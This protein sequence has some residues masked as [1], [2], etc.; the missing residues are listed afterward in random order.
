M[1]KLLIAAQ[2]IF[3]GIHATHCAD[4]LTTYQQAEDRIRLARAAR[5]TPLHHAARDGH[6]A[7]IGALLSV[8]VDVNQRDSAGCTPLLIAIGYTATASV[9]KLLA[10]GADPNAQ[11]LIDGCIYT[12]LHLA[13]LLGNVDSLHELLA[14]RPNL[15]TKTSIGGFTALHLAALYKRI[16]CWNILINMGADAT[17]TD[18]IGRTPVQIAKE[19]GL[20]ANENVGDSGGCSIQ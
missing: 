20:I 10:C 6:V 12:A 2:V 13:V 19:Q 11:A 18:V 1:N 16:P 17:V 14:Y 9:R 15:E 4:T 7:H 5:M 8:G 3:L